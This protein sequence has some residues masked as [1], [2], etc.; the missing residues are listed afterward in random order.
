MKCNAK[1]I[2][3]ENFC[4]NNM[5]M[6]LKAPEIA[7]KTNPGQFVNILCSSEN[8]LTLRRPISIMDADSAKGTIDI[9]YEIRGEGTKLLAERRAGEIVDIMGP[10]GNGFLVDETFKHIAIVGGGIGIYP[11]YYLAKK[12][13]GCDI[14]VYMGYQCAEK[15]VL[16][17]EFDKEGCR[18][19]LCTD[20][21]S[22]GH[23][24]Y[25]TDVFFKNYNKGMYDM[26]FVCGPEL[27]SRKVV[28]LV[29]SSADRVQVSLEE[30]MGCGIGACLV[31]SCEV[32]TAE[33]I[34]MKTVCKDGPVFDGSIVFPEV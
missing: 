12:Y 17:E 2:S 27:M 7:L 33:G 14:D 5:L 13:S 22:I 1:V 31:C 25:V 8:K 6:K 3:N 16:E 4:D 18:V 26:V 10:L 19:Y 20:D 15:V 34:V 24:G 30:R 9:A 29:R 28:G 21:G 23:S 32:K 11:L